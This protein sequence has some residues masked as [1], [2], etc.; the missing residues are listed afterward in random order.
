MISN[1]R[2]EPA[3]SSLW[4]HRAD[5]EVFSSWHGEAEG[6]AR[7]DKK[8]KRHTPALSASNSKQENHEQALQRPP[9]KSAHG[10]ILGNYYSP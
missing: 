7:G 8:W 1:M 10:P 6:A 5:G 2:T 9:G 3:T 4:G